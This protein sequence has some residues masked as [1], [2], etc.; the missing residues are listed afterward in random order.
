MRR[1]RTGAVSHLFQLPVLG[2]AVTVM[3]L[4]GYRQVTRI[5]R[6]SMAVLV[7]QSA[8]AAGTVV[9][10]DA[11]EQVKMSADDVPDGAITEPSTIEGKRLSKSKEEGDVFVRDDFSSPSRYASKGFSS[12]IPDGRVMTTLTIQNITL[13]ASGLRRGDR[14]DILVSGKTTDRQRGAR[15]VITDAFVLGYVNPSLP[16]QAEQGTGPFGMDLS[17]KTKRRG[18]DPTSLLLALEPND[19][20]PLAEIDGAGAHISVVLH[21]I[22]ELESGDPL[23]IST[24]P[25]AKSVDVIVGAQRERVI[26]P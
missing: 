18:K 2:A 8:L 4:L 11:L 7:A 12:V 25:R 19:V 13:P 3:G 6:P 17:P 9:D 5:A 22:E 16:Q 21:S 23:V 26:V 10:E 1:T 14:V 24:R 15:I 20:L